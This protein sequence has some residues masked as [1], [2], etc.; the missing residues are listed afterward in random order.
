LALFDIPG[1]LFSATAQLVPIDAA[2]ALS[3]F[4]LAGRCTYRG[5][6]DYEFDG[7]YE[8]LTDIWVNC[9]STGATTYVVAA[10]PPDNAFVTVVIVT[11]V[12]DRDEEARNRIWASFEVE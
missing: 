12:A 10:A 2:F 4:D 7:L 5:R 3:Q 1:V 9:G 11:A 6:E 8:G